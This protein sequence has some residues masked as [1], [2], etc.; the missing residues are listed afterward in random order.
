MWNIPVVAPEELNVELSS[1]TKRNKLSEIWIENTKKFHS[2]KCIWKCPLQSGTIMF[3]PQCVVNA[4]NLKC[5]LT[6][7]HICHLKLVFVDRAPQTAVKQ[8][9]SSTQC[10]LKQCKEIHHSKHSI[11]SV[12]HLPQS[13]W[14]NPEEYGYIIHT[15]SVRTYNTVKKNPKK[16]VSKKNIFHDI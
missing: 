1:W 5:Y 4:T 13:Q 10:A 12:V 7:S 3:W 2:T 11:D 9:H 8:F 14:S 15:D 16:T 6:E